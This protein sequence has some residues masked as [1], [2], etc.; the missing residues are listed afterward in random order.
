MPKEWDVFISHASEDKDDFVRPLAQAL[1][2]LGVKIWYDE[3]TLEVGDSLSRSIDNGLAE[4]RYGVVVISPSF[5]QKKWPERELRGLVAREVEEEQ[6]VI[7]PIWFGVTKQEVLNFS[8]PLGDT[9]AVTTEGVTAE[10]VALSLLKTIRPDIY[11]G[12]PRAELEKMLNGEAIQE[13]QEELEDVRDDLAQFQCPYCQAPLSY[14]NE[15]VLD[16][17][18]GVEGTV[19]TFAC[20]YTDGDGG[21]LERFCPSDPRFPKFE[22]FDLDVREA[23]GQW[24]CYVRPS[25]KHAQHLSILRGVAWSEEEARDQVLRNYERAARKWK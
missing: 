11:N 6:K 20:G 13:L 1:A 10:D 18:L 19:E 7:L 22:E 12:H 25:T 15:V 8:P 17:D 14:R 9:V 21:G 23:N 24:T 2:Q 16:A 3:F 5:I 4:S